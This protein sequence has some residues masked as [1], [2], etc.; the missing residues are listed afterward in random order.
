MNYLDLVQNFQIF[1]LTHPVL[2]TFLHG[3][4]P[5]VN[6]ATRSFND[7]PL[8]NLRLNSVSIS[9]PNSS[10]S[11]TITFSIE[12][13]LLDVLLHDRSNEVYILNNLSNIIKDLYSQSF[14]Y[15]NLIN[16]YSATPG[17]FYMSENLFGFQLTLDLEFSL[18][19][20][21]C[22]EPSFIEGYDV[23]AINLLIKAG[24]TD[25]NTINSY[26]EFV[27]DLKSAGFWTKFKYLYPLLGDTP[28]TQ[29]WNAINPVDSPSAFRLDF[30]DIEHSSKGFRGIEFSTGANYATPSAYAS[31]NYNPFVQGSDGIDTLYGVFVSQF[32]GPNNNTQGEFAYDFGSGVVTGWTTMKTRTSTNNFAFDISS[33]GSINDGHFGSST[34]SRGLYAIWRTAQNATRSYRGSTGTFY[35]VTPGT[36]PFAGAPDSILLLSNINRGSGSTIQLPQPPSPILTASFKWIGLAFAIDT[37][38]DS[39]VVS[40]NSIINNFMTSIGR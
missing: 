21:F 11:Q 30:N 6:A 37:L 3:E 35:S 22:I 34:N 7:F 14:I 24:I 5:V 9:T 1:V 13:T 23:D 18:G 2:K 39:E 28:S 36:I 20:A 16:N 4:I 8:L 31:T 17:P 15:N 27:L 25:T 40:L 19:D 10:L 26:N 38:T 12:V 32:I 29:K 33:D